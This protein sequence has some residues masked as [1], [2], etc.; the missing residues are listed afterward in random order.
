MRLVNYCEKPAFK[1]IVYLI[2][3][4]CQAAGTKKMLNYLLKISR[5]CLSRSDLIR[6]MRRGSQLPHGAG[7]AAVD[8]RIHVIGA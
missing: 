2:N 3:N 4:G 6:E 5:V 8:L 7:D 1:I